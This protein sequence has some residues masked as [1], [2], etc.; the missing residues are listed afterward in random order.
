MRK[1][2][3][4][5]TR[6]RAWSP[7]YRVTGALKSS[8]T[9]VWR[10]GRGAESTKVSLHSVRMPRRHWMKI[11]LGRQDLTCELEGETLRIFPL[12]H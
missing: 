6:S 9:R 5:I 10:I 4:K 2:D 3:G 8:S 7:A 12:D 11:L 1:L